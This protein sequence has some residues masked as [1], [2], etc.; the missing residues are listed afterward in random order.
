MTEIDEAKGISR[1][2]SSLWREM[3]ERKEDDIAHLTALN[4]ELLAACLQ[5]VYIDKQLDDRTRLLI[6]PARRMAEAAIAKAE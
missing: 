1:D 2:I 5:L 6:S 4:A 3:C